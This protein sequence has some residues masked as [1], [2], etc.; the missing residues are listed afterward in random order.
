MN[1]VVEKWVPSGKSQKFAYKWGIGHGWGVA[2]KWG[3]KKTSGWLV[4]GC[5]LGGALGFESALGAMHLQK[6]L[7]HCDRK[8]GA[9]QTKT[10]TASKR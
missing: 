8:V 5:W 3:V 6:H 9:T 4:A 7:V 10:K 2:Y 1:G